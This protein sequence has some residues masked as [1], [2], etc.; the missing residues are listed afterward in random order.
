MFPYLI[1]LGA[2]W[3][4][5]VNDNDQSKDLN[6]Q[7]QNQ[8]FF[9]KHLCHSGAELRKFVIGQLLVDHLGD[10]PDDLPVYSCL[11]KRDSEED[12]VKDKMFILPGREDSGQ[13]MFV[14]HDPLCSH[15]CPASYM[16]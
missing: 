12:T 11:L 13:G 8:N 14:G 7:E 4:Q 5:N 16:S 15:R 2:T 10:D 9:K 3:N 1:R 6:F